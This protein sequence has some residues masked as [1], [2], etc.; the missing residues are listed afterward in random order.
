MNP[1]AN[2]LV[3]E[4]ISVENDFSSSSHV[5]D[6]LVTESEPPASIYSIPDRY[7][8]DTLR[9]L[10]VNTK[11]Y[12]VYWEISD[13]TL[14]EKGLDLNKDELSFKVYESNGNE[15]FEFKSS[16]ALGEYFVNLQFENMDIYV[17]AGI[18]EN[19]KFIEILDSNKV[20]TFSS[21]INIPEENDEVWLRKKFAWTE[22]LRSTMQNESFGTSS[23]Q[24]VEELERLKY[25]IEVE[26]EKLSS[27]SL[28]QG[29]NND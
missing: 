20:R 19:D 28:H 10:L 14:E 17:K 1:N 6:T 22:V 4:S 9:V 11:K 21:K 7:N 16:F 13:K 29:I 26:E 8:K 15:L 23:A 5:L 2:K 24:Y 3:K 25:F 18:F 12:Y 27:S